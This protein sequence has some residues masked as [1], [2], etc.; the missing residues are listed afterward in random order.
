MTPKA[1]KQLTKTESMHRAGNQ[2]MGRPPHWR[3]MGRQLRLAW[4]SFLCCGILAGCDAPSAPHRL[5]NVVAVESSPERVAMKDL[6]ED[7]VETSPRSEDESEE[8]ETEAKETAP[9]AKRILLGEPGHRYPLLQDIPA[10][11]LPDKPALMVHPRDDDRLE[12]RIPLEAGEVVWGFGP[13]Y[14]AFNMRASQ[15][16]S[17]AKDAWNDMSSS[18][19]AVPFYISS[20]GYGLFINSSGKVEF[21]IGAAQSNELSIVIPEPGVE[22]ITFQGN[23]AEISRAYTE[24][25]G[26]PAAAPAWIFRPWMSRNSY[27]SA[28]EVNRVLRRMEELGMPVGVVVLE[29]WAEELHNFRFER[30]RYPNPITWIRQLK[31]AGVHVVCWITPSVLPGTEAHEQARE[32]GYLVLEEDGSEHIVRWLEHGR[33]IDFRIPDARDWWRDLQKPLV[34]MGISGIKTD[35]GEHM[36]DPFFHNKHPYY[37]Q[38][39]SLDAFRESAR[40]GITFSRSGNPRT[41]GLGAVWA[42]DQQ[43]K[44]SRLAGVVRAGLSAAVSGYPLW[45]H[46]IGGY[47]GVPTKDLY[48]RWLQFGAFSPIMQFHGEQPREPWRYDRETLEVAQFYFTVRERLLPFL[49]Q[50][51]E[52]AVADGT[53]IIRPLPWHF[54]NDPD[55]Y[56]IDDQFMLGPDLLVAPMVEPQSERSIYLPD[57]EWIDLW[58]GASHTGPVHRTHT[59]ELLEIP[60]F[61]RAE[62]Y[63][64]YRDLF[65]DA[66]HKP[67]PAPIAVE[68]VAPQDA[69]D[70]VPDRMYLR[71]TESIDLTYRITNNTDEPAHISV[72]LAPAAGIAVSPRQLVRFPLAPGTNREITF[73][74]NATP[75]H[76]PGTY[77]LTLEVRR[78]GRDV[79]APTLDLVLSPSWKV[80]GLFDGGVAS[81]QELDD[82]PVDIEASHEDRD[83]KRITWKDVPSEAM[84]PDGLIDLADIV[85]DDDYSTSY[86]Y[87]TIFSRWPRRVQIR[88]GSG[89]A[90]TIWINGR[91]VLHHPV[92]RN[93]E[94]GEDIIEPVLIGG[95]NHV[96][97]RI[98]RDIAP[99]Q[100]YFR[101]N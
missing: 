101:I 32:R 51:G 65:S 90:M 9:S 66:P 63:A 16:E 12:L 73:T 6:Q 71:G 25:V 45:G 56:G 29:A 74:V 22:L 40:E 98:S 96:L 80:L 94:Q 52:Q 46:D 8:T 27:L 11:D 53:P 3:S 77:P 91:E 76:T 60:V 7:E 55:T 43:A 44:W 70:I 13:R 72:R 14:E 2:Q 82:E 31:R 88:T 86:V 35:G 37:Y 17:W 21:D 18:Y 59:A 34:E 93:P 69:R 15:I 23:P 64:D 54:P 97:V 49:E 61:A 58:S 39:A 81:E 48:I 4:C 20:R 62:A 92:H 99:H 30:R 36:P 57:G 33:K 75:H 89:D 100:F 38:R 85:G 41:A 95:L 5:D 10:G 28:Y 19:F 50:W 26:R 24:L 87:T 1:E 67:A 42:G 78:G 84:R 47:S 79:P 83:G 68:A